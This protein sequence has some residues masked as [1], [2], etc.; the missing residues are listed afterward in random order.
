MLCSQGTDVPFD[1]TMS[2]VLVPNAMSLYYEIIAA[3]ALAE[4]EHGQGCIDDPH[5]GTPFQPCKTHSCNISYLQIVRIVLK[6]LST[7]VNFV[8]VLPKYL[9]EGFKIPYITSVVLSF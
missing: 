4:T 9:Y 6:N 7:Y 2:T 1:G 5:A 8:F 3:T